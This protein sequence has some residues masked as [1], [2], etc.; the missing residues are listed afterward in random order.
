MLNGILEFD[1]FVFFFW[2]IFV[3]VHDG[4]YIDVGC[5]VN[6]IDKI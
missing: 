4:V 3:N 1:G 5:I 2:K 6:D